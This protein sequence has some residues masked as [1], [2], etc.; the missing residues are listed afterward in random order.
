M[1][2]W[3]T[4]KAK[5][6]IY[7]RLF[8]MWLPV[9]LSLLKPGKCLNLFSTGNKMFL[10]CGTIQSLFRSFGKATKDIWGLFLS[11]Y[12][13][14]VH[15]LR[16]LRDSLKRKGN[17]MINEGSNHSFFFTNQAKNATPFQ[18]I[19]ALLVILQL[20]IWDE[21]FKNIQEWKTTKTLSYFCL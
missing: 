17:W 7:F 12:T 19:R 1:K 18:V 14:G 20:R 2:T 11:V 21:V 9:R 4:F 16:S 3:Q 5:A 15:A 6:L 8:S 10:M 13:F